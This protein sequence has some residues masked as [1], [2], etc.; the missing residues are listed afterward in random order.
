MHTYVLLKNG[1]IKVL[2]S[3]NSLKNII[4]VY[5]KNDKKV[6]ETISMNDIVVTDS[7]IEVLKMYKG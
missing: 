3:E 7:N 6:L 4:E 5:S 2:Y 1:Q